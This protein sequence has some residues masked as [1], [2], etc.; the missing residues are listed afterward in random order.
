MVEDFVGQWLRLRNL[1][2]RVVPDILMFPDFD[3]NVRQAFRTET[4]MFFG[5][6]MREDMSALDLLDADFTFLNERLAKHYGIEGVYGPRF[7]R[8]EIEDPNRRGLLGHGSVLSLTSVATRT[9]PVLR[10]VYILGTFLNTPPPPPPPVVPALEE[11]DSVAAPKTVREQLETHRANPVCASCHRVIDPVGFALENFNSVGQWREADLNGSPIDATGTLADGS[12]VGSPVE[13]RQV[14]LSR[15]DAFVTILTERMMTYALG[16]G[17]EPVD[18][19]V[20]RDIVTRASQDDYSFMTII[21]GIVES[22]PFQ[23]RTK[24]EE[25]ENVGTIAQADTRVN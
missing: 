7:R 15:P 22:E 2:S 10:G 20:V 3:D 1:E 17:L 13:L 14:I 24:L 5:Y 12:A 16:R 18:M 21:S 9:S 4:E 8:V 6:V 23:S 11:S 25:P 19:A